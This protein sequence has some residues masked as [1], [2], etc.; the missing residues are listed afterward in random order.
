[1]AGVHWQDQE[2]MEKFKCKDVNADAALDSDSAE[3]EHTDSD[4]ESSHTAA[5]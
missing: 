5:L 2:L 1:V 3:S 4:D